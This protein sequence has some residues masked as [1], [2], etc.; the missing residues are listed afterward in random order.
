MPNYPG[1]TLMKTIKVLFL[2]E[3]GVEFFARTKRT[4]KGDVVVSEQK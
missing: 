4:Q 1:F 3:T 2:Q